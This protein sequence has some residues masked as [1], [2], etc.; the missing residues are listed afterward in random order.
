M[1]TKQNICE[2]GQVEEKGSMLNHFTEA[3]P[4]YRVYTWC[5]KLWRDAHILV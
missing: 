2:I 4:A 5:N 3:M 1:S